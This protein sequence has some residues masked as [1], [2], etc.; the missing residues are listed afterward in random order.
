MMGVHQHQHQQHPQQWTLA[1]ESLL[2]V[3]YHMNTIL[4]VLLTA[5]FVAFVVNVVFQGKK[6]VQKLN[7]RVSGVKDA[8]S[9]L[10]QQKKKNS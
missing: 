8:I 1:S 10:S 5:L 2:Y 9:N 7:T 4:Y 6:G 3:L